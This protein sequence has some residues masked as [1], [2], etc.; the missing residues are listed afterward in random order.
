MKK[1]VSLFVILSMI[2]AFVPSFDNGTVY[3]ATT[4]SGKL[5]D[6]IS[7][8]ITDT[9]TF[10]I[11]GSGKIKYPSA[12]DREE[13]IAKWEKYADKAKKLVISSGITGWTE[14]SLDSFDN[15]TSV[16]IPGTVT[17]IRTSA[18]YGITSLTTV[19][20]KEGVERIKAEAFMGCKNLKTVNLPD[21]LEVIETQAFYNTAISQI[22]IPKGM[23]TIGSMAFGHCL[24]L[25]YV[26]IENGLKYIHDCAFREC[27]ELNAITFPKSLE[28]LGSDIFDFCDQTINV[29]FRGDAPEFEDNTFSNNTIIAFYPEGNKTWTKSVRH[30]YSDTYSDVEWR[31][32]NASTLERPV[33]TLSNVSSSGKIKI[34]W[35]MVPAATK[36]E[37]YRATSKDGT[38]KKLGTT[39][40]LKFT[41]TSATPGYKYYYKVRAVDA[42]G[43][44]SKYSYKKYRTCDC[45][46]PKL[47]ITNRA[48]DGK[49][50]VNWSAVTGASKYEIYRSTNE[51]G[52]YKK[53]FTTSNTK[54]TNTSAVNGKEYYYKIKAICKKTSAGNSALS[55]AYYKRCVCARPTNF[56]VT[57]DTES[58]K[59]LLTWDAVPKAKKYE[60]FRATKENGNYYSKGTTSETTFID[61]SAK[62]GN[63]YYY[64]IKASTMTGNNN[65]Y[66]SSYSAM[67]KISL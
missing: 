63:T 53:I 33:I 6:N 47:E 48:S 14:E 66:D 4:A 19:T 21:S 2:F 54:Y 17:N 29:C 43:N 50:I 7:W 52:E 55:K 58:G 37:V 20:L 61:T 18:F 8:K 25:K 51:E 12:L 49:P 41:N 16:T 42:D 45:A 26:D 64:K 31:S 56:A 13:R 38:Y 15:I 57:C 65:N 59:P 60:I 10:T 40:N 9:G 27:S 35:T 24:N 32:Y 44:K 36:Y 39:R 30:D 46:T 23:D 67:V 22:T 3:A 62:E 34:S 11:S 28:S 5:T 1:I